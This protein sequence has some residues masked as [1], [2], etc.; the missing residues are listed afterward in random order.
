V[1]KL[2]DGAR[3]GEQEAEVGGDRVGGGGSKRWKRA[4]DRGRS[5]S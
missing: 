5:R 4:E 2:G 3:G 1:E